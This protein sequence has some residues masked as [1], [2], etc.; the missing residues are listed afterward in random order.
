VGHLVGVGCECAAMV[1]SVA[2]TIMRLS[3]RGKA[4]IGVG[5]G[6]CSVG[7]ICDISK[8]TPSR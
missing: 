7:D 4:V 2:R 5:I 3:L 1:V 8:Y 6:G